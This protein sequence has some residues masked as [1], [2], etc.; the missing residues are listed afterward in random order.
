MM[1]LEDQLR[2]ERECTRLCNDFAW[3]VD[4]FHYDA[5]VSLFTPDGVFDR[6]GQVSRGGVEI[7]KFLN[8]RPADRV[9]RHVCTNIRIDLVSPEAAAGNCYTLVFQAQAE[10]AASLPRPTPLPMVVEYHDDYSL[11]DEGWKI[12]HRKLK[13]VFQP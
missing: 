1:N 3:A 12:Q 2:C 7:R 11:T 5:F 10:T 8:A 13:I 9:T 6:A 4:T